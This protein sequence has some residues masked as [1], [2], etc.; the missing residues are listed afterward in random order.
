VDDLND[1]IEPLGGNRLIPLLKD[2]DAEWDYPAITT[3]AL[4]KNQKIGM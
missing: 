3:K 4:K 2:P 1:W